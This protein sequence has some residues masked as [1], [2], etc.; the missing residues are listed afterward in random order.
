MSFASS[1]QRF[2][3]AQLGALLVATAIALSVLPFV[4]GIG[5]FWSLVMLAGSGLVFAAEQRAAGKPLWPPL[6]GLPQGVWHP[7]VRLLFTLLTWA[8]AV[9]AL[10]FGIAPLLWLGA[11][12]MLGGDLVR[13][14]LPGGLA[15][16]TGRRRL[17]VVALG[18]CLLGFLLPWWS[19]GGFF[20][21][22]LE[23]RYVSQTPDLLVDE[24]YAGHWRNDYNSTAWYV[25]KMQGKG[26]NQ[27]FSVS[28]L[29]ALFLL[30]GLLLREGP[31]ERP[32]L[33]LWLAGGL[34]FWFLVLAEGTGVGRWVFLPGLVLLG[35]LA[36]R[37][38]QEH[39]AAPPVPPAPP[40]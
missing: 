8:H 40:A 10:D 33:P 36:F 21:G 32:A 2:S 1:L 22:A 18:L 31:V 9:Q 15:L 13:A 34:G 24:P 35:V 6:E 19:W 39:P 38:F 27:S 14:A 3:R 16:P 12:W 23:S 28:A 4:E 20:R 25:P 7:R 17:V 37:Q 11:S 29:V 30:A 26:R 5:Y